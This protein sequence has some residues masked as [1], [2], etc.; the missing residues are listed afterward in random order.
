MSEKF[1]TRP[2]VPATPLAEES[3]ARELDST[4]P[5]QGSAAPAQ[6]STDPA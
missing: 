5:A 4:A 1:D 3:T 6:D 2:R